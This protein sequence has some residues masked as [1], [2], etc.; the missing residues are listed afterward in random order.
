MLSFSSLTRV[1]TMAVKSGL[2]ESGAAGG[3]WVAM[4]VYD[5][6]PSLFVIRT[7]CKVSFLGE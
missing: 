1:S 3:V 4:R 5:G 2:L 7:R 6:V